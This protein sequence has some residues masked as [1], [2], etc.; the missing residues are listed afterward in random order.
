MSWIAIDDEVAAILHILNTPSLSGPVNATA[1]NPVTNTEFTAALGRAL[2][3]PTILPTP[4]LGLKVVFGGELVDTLLGSQRVSSAKLQSSGF[5]FA[6]PDL[7]GAL[8]SVLHP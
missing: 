1:P 8:D 4:M 7:D 5:E 3:R 6:Q 2:H